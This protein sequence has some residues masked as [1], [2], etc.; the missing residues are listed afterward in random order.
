MLRHQQGL[1]QKQA[2]QQKLSPQQIQYIKLLQMTTQALEHRIKEELELNPTLEDPD[3]NL[4]TGREEPSDER[5]TQDTENDVDDRSEVDWDSYYSDSAGNESGSS[6]TS[7]NPDKPDWQDIP[8]PYQESQIEA[9]EN[10]VMLLDLSEKQQLIADQIIGSI[11]NDGYFR[12][13]LQ[14]VADGIAFQTGVPVRYEEAEELLHLIQRLDPP[15]IAARNLR[16]CLLIQL[17]VFNKD[18]HPDKNRAYEIIRNYWDEFEKKHFEKIMRQMDVSQDDFKAAYEEIIHLD[19][20]PGAFES[21]SVSG[22][23]YIV[24]DFEV[25]YEP[26]FAEGDPIDGEKEGDFII[27]MHKKNLPNLRISKRY[28]RLYEELKAQPNTPANKQTRAFI[29]E[30]LESAKAFM[31]MISQ[32]KNT[33]MNVMQTIIALQEDFFKTGKNLRP[34][35]L[36]DV[37]NRI[38]MDVSTISRVVNGKY[39]STAFGV[40]ELKYFFNEGIQTESGEDVS[41][42]EVKNLLAEMIDNEPKDKP[43]S[44]Q[45]LVDLLN[46]KGF[47]LARRT[48]TKYREQLKYPPARL[49]KSIV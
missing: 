4:D 18:H 33:L 31:E 7:Y 27:L 15:G 49:R 46:E 2:L 26:D 1:Y 10:Q 14:S 35:I 36:K 45:K 43:Y 34:M 37:A 48:V 11:G 5:E 41:N 25:Y 30:K 29:K 21:A 38:N 6:S 19:P 9:L 28:Q 20:K 13:D 23:Q 22:N 8:T 17:E 16:E 32:R 42:R 3:Q 47:K 40:Y 24:P 12:R 39:V 44:D